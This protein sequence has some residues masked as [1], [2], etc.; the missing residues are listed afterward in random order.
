MPLYEPRQDRRVEAHVVTASNLEMIEEFT[1]GSI[2]GMMLPRDQR[3]VDWYNPVTD[4]YHEASVGEVVVKHADKD[5]R[6][7]SQHCFDLEYKEAAEPR[8]P[9][10]PKSCEPHWYTGPDDSGPVYEPLHLDAV[11]MEPKA[12]ATS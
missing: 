4:R 10:K 2:K 12:K 3:R 8:Q 9:W 7:T 11:F 6:V 1:R 5:I